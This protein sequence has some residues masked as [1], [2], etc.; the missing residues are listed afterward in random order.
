M[1]LQIIEFSIEGV[2]GGCVNMKL[3]RLEGLLLLC[4][5]I[6]IEIILVILFDI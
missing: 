3:K 4:F 6:E 2:L 5:I 1:K